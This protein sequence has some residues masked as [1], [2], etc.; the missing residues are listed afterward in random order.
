MKD[1]S[2]L[3]GAPVAHRGF[4][5]PGI[6]ENSMAA[7]DAAIRNGFAIE[8]D[9]HMTK[10]GVLVV[11]HDDS[12]VRMTSCNKYIEDCTFAEIRELMLDSTNERIPA[13]A[14]VLDS[15]NGRAGL[16]IEIK[17]H[18]R[19]G[20]VEEI[21]SRMLDRYCGKFAV[22]SFDPWIVRWFLINRPSYI[23]GQISGGLKGKKL[24]VL[25]RF[26]LKNLVVT[27]LCRPDFIAYEYQ[28][29]NSWIRFFAGFFRIP[30][31][32][33]T[34]RDPETAKKCRDAGLNSIFEGFYCK[35]I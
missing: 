4:H 26:L 10:D 17:Q 5:S 3:L 21:L 25:Q 33:W 14:D 27:F 11:F 15:V 16:L 7:F 32:V 8:L 28:Y 23:R 19:T 2:W 24:P 31:I 34:V 29:L 13:L 6:P 18:P 20:I 9:V 30:V 1:L 35:K 12:M 22:V